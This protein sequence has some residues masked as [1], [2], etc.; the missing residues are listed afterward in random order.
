MLTLNYFQGLASELLLGKKKMMLA[1]EV[2]GIGIT[3]AKT[4]TAYTLT[5][6][7]KYIFLANHFGKSSVL[8]SIS[9]EV[10]KVSTSLGRE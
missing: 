1:Q 6:L 5:I 3:T 4:T 2:S 8:C 9:G 7:R 10:S